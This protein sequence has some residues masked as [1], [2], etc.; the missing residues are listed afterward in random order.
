[1]KRHWWSMAAPDDVT[2]R[3]IAELELHLLDR[4]V[5]RVRAGLQRL[6][7]AHRSSIEALLADRGEAWVRKNW[8]LLVAEM[9]YVDTL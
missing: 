1:M 2:E 7:S 9:E 5:V 6:S 3:W 8:A 4:E